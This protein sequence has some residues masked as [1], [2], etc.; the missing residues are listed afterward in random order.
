MSKRRGYND[1]Y[2][3]LYNKYNIEELNFF[4]SLSIQKKDEI[5]DIEMQI[6]SYKPFKEPL[7]FKFLSMNT[8]IS[9]KICILRKYEEFIRLSPFSSEYSKLNKW[10]N[11]KKIIHNQLI[12][13]KISFILKIKVQYANH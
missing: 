4:K 9:N 6:D 1:K 10:I 3:Q 12:I 13:F 5:Y 2:K 7:R 8:T 11:I